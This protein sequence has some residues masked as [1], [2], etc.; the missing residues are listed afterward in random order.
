MVRYILGRVGAMALTLF[1]ILTLAFLTVRLMPGSVYDDPDLP[2]AVQEALE[3]RLHLGEPPL[4][5]YGYFLRGVVLEGD[6]GTSVKLEPGVPA[7]RVLTRRIPVSLGIN[8]LALVLALPLGIMTGTAAALGK[9]KRSGRALSLAVSVSIAVPSFV[10]AALLQYLLGF[11]LGLFPLVYRPGNIASLVLPVLALAL[12]PAAT[13]TRYVRGEL[14]ALIHADFMI[15]A[16]AKGLSRRAALLRHGLRSAGV[17]LVTVISPMVA[18]LLGGSLVVEGIFAIPG[19]GGIMVDAINARDHA[20]T[21][22]ALIFYSAVSLTTLL[23]ADV[24]YGL[25]DPRI[26]MGGAA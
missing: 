11:K 15:L 4:R 14:T 3:A 7:F 21:V 22:A 6:W 19:V 13:V 5:Q 16:R 17:T 2:P 26:R 1:V 24:T 9:G 18:G 23:L 20:L 12:G 8:L 10:V 25:I